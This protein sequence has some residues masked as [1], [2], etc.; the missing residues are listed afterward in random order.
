MRSGHA[1][2]NSAILRNAGQNGYDWSSRSYST[3]TNAYNLNF[4]ASD[5]NP[6]NYNNRWNGFPLRCLALC[7][8]GVPIFYT[9][10]PIWR[11]WQKRELIFLVA[12]RS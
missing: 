6:S 7:R 1:N 2:V 10:Y 4:N 8:G 5:V 12:S 11:P 9:Y 3:T